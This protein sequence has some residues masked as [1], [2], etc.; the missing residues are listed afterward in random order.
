MN[1]VFKM[2][3]AEEKDIRNNLT[4]RTSDLL[5]RVFAMQDGK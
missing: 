3:A 4:S 2:V 5:K 1:G